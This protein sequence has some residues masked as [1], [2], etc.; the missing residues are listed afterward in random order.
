MS[1]RP[2]VLFPLFAELTALDGVGP[3]TARLLARLDIAHPA[4]LILTLPTGGV[5][6]RLRASIREAHPPEVVT[7]EVEVGLHQ[8][9]SSRTRPYRVH[10]RDALTEF[11]LVFFH[12]R[13]DWLR[14]DAAGRPAPRRLRQGRALRRPRPDGPPRPHPAPRRA[15]AARVRA[16]LPADRGPDPAR[17]DPRRPRGA[18]PRPRP[19]RMDRAEPHAPP[20]VARLAR[21]PRPRPRPG[22]P[23]R[24]R[25]R[26]RPPASASPT[27]SSSPT[28]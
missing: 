18:R 8:P 27:T 2:E 23:R 6:R 19:A 25:A 4:D 1:P 5:D 10:V 17:D 28:R 11:Q 13:E 21:G 7:V 26:P 15:S 20:R 12:A 22:P 9:G 3:K 16:G 14:R 24:P